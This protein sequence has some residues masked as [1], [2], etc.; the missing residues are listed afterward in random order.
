MKRLENDIKSKD[1]KSVYLLYGD[2]EYLKKIYKDRLYKN[3]VSN[4]I[5]FNKYEGKDIK[6]D[7]IIELAKSIPFFE[8]KR[9]ILIE[10][11]MWFKSVDEKIIEYLD[12]ML[13]NT[14]LIFVENSV[15]KRSKF[16]KEIEKRGLAVELSKPSDKDLLEWTFR[17]IDR[18]GKKITRSNLELILDYAGDNMDN[19]KNELDKLISYV[20][21]DVIEK[22]DIDTIITINPQNH[23]FDMIDAI[24]KKQTKY[25]LKLYEDLLLMKEAPMYIL[26]MITRQFN[27]LLQVK[28]LLE[29]G[30]NKKEIATA[31][32]IS[33]YIAN[34]LMVK[35]KNFDKRVL[36]IYLSECINLEEMIKSGKIID[37]MAVEFLLLGV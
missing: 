21:N 9:C 15:D 8:K 4:P 24:L 16:Y 35:I 6:V 5:N 25:A 14:I 18:A 1:F 28:S 12:I 32:G 27:Q 33:E 34:K 30:L 17:I 20:E 2:E 3:I 31:L 36:K 23:I 29:E 7:D 26:V 11:S 10:N 13:E 19:L 37:R 22:K